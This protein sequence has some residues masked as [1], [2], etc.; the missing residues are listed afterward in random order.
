MFL[1][2]R[3]KM[4]FVEERRVQA[5]VGAAAAGAGGA[6]QGYL[7]RVVKYV[8]AEVIA[9][10]LALNGFVAAA[11]GYETVYWIVFLVCLV[12]VPLYVW[13]TTRTPKERLFNGVLATIAFLVWAYATGGGL[14]GYLDIHYPLYGSVALVLFT[15]VSGLFEPTTNVP[16][17]VPPSSGSAAAQ[18]VTA[19]PALPT[20]S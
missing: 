14:P 3:S 6:D 8:P 11:K 2:K 19:T 7:E 18:P 13:R 1:A 10:Y 12:C 15:L 4:R 17:P 20:G 16:A 5:G 9:A